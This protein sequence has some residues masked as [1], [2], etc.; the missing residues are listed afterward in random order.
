MDKNVG[1]RKA[2][3]GH[4]PPDAVCAGE[5]INGMIDLIFD[6]AKFVEICFYTG[7][8]VYHLARAVVY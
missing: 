6:V 7:F 1:M 3:K 5:N 2:T 8:T 4:I